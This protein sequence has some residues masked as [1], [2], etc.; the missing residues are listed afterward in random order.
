MYQT[1]CISLILN[2]IKLY[3]IYTIHIYS[4]ITVHTNYFIAKKNNNNAH[5]I[6]VHITNKHSL[7]TLRIKDIEIVK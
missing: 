1:L 7:F 5:I 2:Y 3:Y 6:H 4:H